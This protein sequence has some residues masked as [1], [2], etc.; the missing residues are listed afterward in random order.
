MKEILKKYHNIL[1]LN[2]LDDENKNSLN[3]YLL[4]YII[5]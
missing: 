2:D 4:L 5:E 1:K 3:A